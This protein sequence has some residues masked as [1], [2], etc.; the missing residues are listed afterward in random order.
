V[1][2]YNQ[3]CGL[4]QFRNYCG[5]IKTAKCGFLWEKTTKRPIASVYTNCET[6]LLVVLLASGT[7][8]S[9][10]VAGSV[11]NGQTTLVLQAGREEPRVVSLQS[12]KLPAWPNG[13][14]ERLIDSVEESGRTVSLHWKLDE[15]DSHISERAAT[16]VYQTSSPRLRLTW[17][18][19]A[20]AEF[21]PVEHSITI[22]NL[23][24]S[25]IWLP[26]QDSFRFRFPVAASQPLE[27][28]YVEKGA[29]KPSD[30]GTHQVPVEAGYRW[31]GRSTTYARDQDEREIIPWFMVER[32]NRTQDGWYVGIEFSGRTRLTL[33]RDAASIYGAA[34][35]DPDPGPFRTRLL[36]H[37]TFA[38]PVVFVG[39][40]TG[41]ADGAGN[42]L[43]PWVRQVLNNPAT[44]KN[45][46]YP[47]LVNNSWGSGMQIDEALA[48]RM[49]RDSAELGL[50]L[51]HIDA[52][53]FRGVGDWYPSPSKFPHGFAPIVT[54]AHRRGLKF[55]IWV[56][57]AQ[58]GVDNNPGALSVHD[59]KIGD[60]LVADVPTG[61]QPE[62]F[63]G[64]T[65][66]LGF[67][68]AREYAR[69]EVERII[70]QY[71]LDML[72]HDG[73]V[74]AKNCSRTDHPHAPAS[75]PQMST[76][77]GNGIAM[78]DNASSSDVSYHAVRD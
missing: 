70:T 77:T 75:P 4:E 6:A 56:D 53:W 32:G 12:G 28:W 58:A 74:V 50:E 62:D 18:W 36:P 57:W 19:E 37:E 51:F 41:G 7:A 22:E 76:V 39:G 68:P 67:P 15:R 45:R 29:G 59:P 64:R 17:K 25:E 35:L 43:R 54:E 65:L 60:W 72:E 2:L 66:D 26:L 38:T 10:Q 16:F 24:S 8:L 78:A 11:H 30:V 44:W 63:V 47:P 49:V 73:Y 40:F 23:S 34:G 31:R 27:H 69:Q 61:W 42:V 9:A 52:G 21:G 13:I 20:R 1:S 71:H 3:C 46:A 55:G 48:L 14:S 33:Q 5:L